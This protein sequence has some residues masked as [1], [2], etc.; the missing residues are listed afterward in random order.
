[1]K[2]L[3]SKKYKR[4]SDHENVLPMIMNSTLKDMSEYVFTINE[5]GTPVM[6]EKERNKFL[7][8]LCTE[9]TKERGED[10][11]DL[12]EADDLGR[13]WGWSRLSRDLD[14]RSHPLILQ[15]FSERK[16]GRFL[17]SEEFEIL[18]VDFVKEEIEIALDRFGA[19]FIRYKGDRVTPLKRDD[20]TRMVESSEFL[21]YEKEKDVSS[22]D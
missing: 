2:L 20:Y 4:N 1:M 11:D 6:E 22:C 3:I 16:L 19:E 12:L 13:P 14:L 17:N 7:H 21:K 5:D 9:V 15:E 8:L 10:G 18:D